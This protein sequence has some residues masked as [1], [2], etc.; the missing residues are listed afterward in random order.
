ME[1]TYERP[2]TCGPEEAPQPARDPLYDEIAVAIAVGQSG[3]AARSRVL[4]T[5]LWDRAEREGDAFHRCVIAHYLADLQDDVVNELAWDIRALEAVEHITPARA[6][7]VHPALRPAGFRPSLHLNVA[8]A[9]RRLGRLAEAREQIA[10]ARSATGALGQDAY[11]AFVRAAIART[12][13]A[14]GVAA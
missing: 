2:T 9:L 6:A 3:E 10:R 13:A 4:L 11:G 7:A 12:E 8:D 14:L 5:A 1:T